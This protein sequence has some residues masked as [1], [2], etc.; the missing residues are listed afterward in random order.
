MVQ[1]APA[2]S[3]DLSFGQ[4][5]RVLPKTGEKRVGGINLSIAMKKYMFPGV[6]LSI[7]LSLFA[8][9]NNSYNQTGI[10]YVNSLALIH[11][12]FNSGKVKEFNEETVNYYSR[13]VPLKNKASVE[14]VAAVV[15]TIRQPGFSYAGVIDKAPLSDFSK[16]LLKDII[17]NKSHLDDKG[18]RTN[19]TLKTNEVLSAGLPAQEKELVLSLIAI[20]Y[21][22]VESFTSARGQ[23]GGCWIT[24]PYGSGPGTQ[25]QCI[26][27]GAL[28][29]GVIGYTICGFFCA[30][31]G[32]IV[33]GVI[34]GLS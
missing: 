2:I 33:G 17:D 27:V 19:L 5:L 14:M 24:G 6:L 1:V 30:L 16:N 34:G 26:I 29:G 4:M 10:D 13:Q 11:A 15:N 31:G 32:A 9:P 3:F 28:L 7:S 12:D 23:D 21:N 8:Q 25:N 22:S 20:A 18:Y